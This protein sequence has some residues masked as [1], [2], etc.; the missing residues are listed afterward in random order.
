MLGTTTG[1]SPRVRLPRTPEDI[2]YQELGTHQLSK[3]RIYFLLQL[4]MSVIDRNRLGFPNRTRYYVYGCRFR[5]RALRLISADILMKYSEVDPR[6]NNCYGSRQK[7]SCIWSELTGLQID[8][9]IYRVNLEDIIIEIFV[10]DG[11]A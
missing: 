11:Y 9:I 2:N 8:G 5:D 4:W 3:P 10:R 7:R 1:S 6:T